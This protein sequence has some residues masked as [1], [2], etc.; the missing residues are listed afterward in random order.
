MPLSTKFQLYRGSQLLKILS[1]STYNI[2]DK[3][4]YTV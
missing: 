2:Q 1:Q 3:L 4:L